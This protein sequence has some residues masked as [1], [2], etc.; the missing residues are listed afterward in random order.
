VP[1]PLVTDEPPDPL[2]VTTVECVGAGGGADDT[3]GELE[4]GGAEV[5]VW[6]TGATLWVGLALGFA[7][8]FVVFLTGWCWAAS[9]AGDGT[10]VTEDTVALVC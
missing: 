5:V 6:V 3:G 10:L 8:V 1:V 9:F 4:T 2:V 7:L